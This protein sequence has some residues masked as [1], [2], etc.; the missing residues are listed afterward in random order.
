MAVY[1]NF[2]FAAA[3]PV[4]QNGCEKEMN[5]TIS[6]VAAVK[7]AGGEK[8]GTVL[9]VAASTSYI[10]TVNGEFIAHGPARC[11][12]GFYKVDTIELSKYLTKKENY[13]AVRVAGYNV[14]AYS[15]LDQPSFVC[16]EILSGKDL[17][18][19]TGKCGFCYY[20]TDERLE[21]VNRYSFQ[22]TFAESYRLENGAFAYEYSD[23]QKKEQIEVSL[24]ESK[25]FIKRDVPYG[26][27]DTV[28]PLMISG[29]KITYSDKGSCYSDRSIK[30]IS[31]IYKGYAEDELEDKAYAD[32][33]R[34]DYS[35]ASPCAAET[36]VFTVKAENYVNLDFK[37]D[38]AGI[39]SFELTA[40]SDGEL[41]FM[42]DEIMTDGKVDEFR[43][44]CTNIIKWSCRRGTYRIVTAEPYTFRYMRVC[45]CKSD[46]KI[47]GLCEHLIEFPRTRITAKPTF[48]D[49]ELKEIYD[50]AVTTFVSNAVDIYMDCPSRERAG[51]LCDSFFTSRVEKVLTG[52]SAVEKAFLANFIIPD[53][54]DAL[55]EGMLPPCYPSDHPNG[56]FIPNW[57]M[58]FFLEIKEYYERTKDSEF[59][60]AAKEK[61][62]KLLGYFRSFENEYG[63]LENLERW[64]FVEWSMANKLT[65]EV[66]FPTNML[67]ARFKATVG[68]LYA[69]QSLIT[70]SERLKETIREMSMTES[71]FF[72]DQAKRENDRLAVGNERTE[73]CQYYAFF[74]DIATPERNK[75]L[76]ETLISDF[77]F[78][79]RETKKYPEIYFANAFIG[80]YMRLEIMQRYGYNEQLISD[81]KDYFGYMAEETGTLWENEKSTA[82]LNHGFA[83]HVIYWFDKM[84]MISR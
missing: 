43:M 39:L 73:A 69:D 42:F 48:G 55:P 46:M 2:K 79:R 65:K 31:P 36:D 34:M 81:I 21:K 5:V 70:E 47:I 44:E 72:A 84:G 49:G 14:N 52:E 24:T 32:A 15:Y 23:C 20:R 7:G 53:R 51:W 76:F 1:E 19:A 11:A 12:H 41:Y 16:A 68:E 26:D 54:F 82:S 56:L 22:R 33:G 66:N 57:A 80:N 10:I 27:Y 62:Y 13:V 37:K 4:W 3:K 9:N 17:K 50:A 59:I 71:G 6:A 77:G 35:A 58:W 29:G 75:W 67:Y 45:A 83:S 18:A 60:R 8:T 64:V 78:K 28:T 25:K 30:D 40:E 38:C 61:A 63:L 74:F